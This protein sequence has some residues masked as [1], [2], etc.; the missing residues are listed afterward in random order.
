M[1]KP[2]KLT[3]AEVAKRARAIDAEAWDA[4]TPKEQRQMVDALNAEI[5]GEAKAR[6]QEKR[7]KEAADAKHRAAMEGFDRKMDILFGRSHKRKR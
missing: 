3:L 7:A 4:K 1:P 6:D 5:Q 2:K